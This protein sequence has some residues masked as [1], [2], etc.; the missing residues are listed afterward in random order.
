MHEIRIYCTKYDY[1]NFHNYTHPLLR[2]I[3]CTY[4]IIGSFRSL[5]VHSLLLYPLSSL[6]LFPADVLQKP[7]PHTRTPALPL[8]Q[9]QPNLQPPHCQYLLSPVLPYPSDTVLH[10]R[11]AVL[12]FL[13]QHPHNSGYQTAAFS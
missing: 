11:Q 3:M 6:L 4:L 8:L 1:P 5:Q 13:L 2:G 7:L 12:S 9:V 10:L